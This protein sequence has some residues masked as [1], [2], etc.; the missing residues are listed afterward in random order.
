M[1]R[2]GL[3]LY[4]KLRNRLRVDGREHLPKTGGALI[5]ANHQSYADIP[6]LAAACPRHLSFL[7]RKSLQ[8]S[9]ALA[10]IMRECG[11]VQ[12]ERGVNDRAALREMVERL[13]RGGLMA[14]FPEGTRTED[15]TVGE[16][17]G[18]AL[19]AAR[20]AGVPIIPAA[21]QGSD[22][23]FPRGRRFPG[24]GRVS[25]RFLPPRSAAGKTALEDVRGDIAAVVELNLARRE[26]KD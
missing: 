13:S 20:K 5:V 4:M 19:L 16:F 24:P 12:I 9:D 10:F 14:I 6:L 2:S 23:I 18:G 21:I 11:A 15:G 17:K 22:M 7:A 26:G 3:G 8:R 25:V 1:L